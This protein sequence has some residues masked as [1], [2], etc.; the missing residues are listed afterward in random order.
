MQNTDAINSVQN[1]KAFVAN[2]L[3]MKVYIILTIIEIKSILYSFQTLRKIKLKLNK[4]AEV[5]LI[6]LEKVVNL[7]YVH[8]HVLEKVEVTII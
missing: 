3:I 2:Q 1:V 6:K 4:K 8:N 5:E 7:K